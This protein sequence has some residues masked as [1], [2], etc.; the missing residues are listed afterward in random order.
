MIKIIKINFFVILLCGC[1]NTNDSLDSQR[2]FKYKYSK[3]FDISSDAIREDLS[4]NNKNEK[5]K[6]D[7]INSEFKAHKIF[8]KNFKGDSIVNLIKEFDKII[9]ISYDEFSKKSEVEDK[10]IS[11]KYRQYIFLL[12]KLNTLTKY[13][14]DKEKL[15]I[16]MYLSKEGE[17]LGKTASFYISL[18][19]NS[20]H[21][22]YL[23]MN[24]FGV[25]ANINSQYFEEYGVVLDL[26]QDQKII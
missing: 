19:L 2:P 12:D 7:S 1:V 9:T 13:D 17:F 18:L 8:P 5:I 24:S 11:I 15:N 25:T 10:L 3:Y 22:K 26:K 21:K 14:A 4:A 20:E 6:K 23:G 16:N